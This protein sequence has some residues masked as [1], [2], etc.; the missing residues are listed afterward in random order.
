MSI[1]HPCL[2]DIILLSAHFC[3]YGVKMSPMDVYDAIKSA[4]DFFRI[5][6]PRVIKDVTDVKNGQT[7]FVNM[8]RRT[9]NDDALFINAKQLVDLNVINKDTFS[10]VITHEA[11]HIATQNIDFPGVNN[12]IWERELAADFFMGCRSGLCNIDEAQLIIGIITKPATPTHPLGLIRNLFFRYGKF[13][14][15][16]MKKKSVPLTM[17]ILLDLFMEYCEEN[18]EDILYYQRQFY[19]FSL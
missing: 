19:R 10:L 5:P 14:S 17:Q 4:C 16:E 3:Y 12:G 15:I 9:Y 11:T 18:K 7:M 13:K 8:D 2:N 1:N 6:V